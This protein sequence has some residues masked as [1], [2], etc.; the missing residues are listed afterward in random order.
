MKIGIV[1]QPLLG[2]YGGIL[3]NYAL[4][5]VLR[6]L[7][8]D[9]ITLDHQAGYSGFPYIWAALKSIICYVL[10]KNSKLIPQY[11]P[12]R[13]NP[14]ISQFVEHYIKTTHTFWNRYKRSLIKQYNIDVLIVGSDQ[15]WRPCYNLRHELQ[16]RFLEF[17]S[18]SDIT[19][20]AYGASFGTSEWE[21]T[22][23]QA[24]QC[25]RLLKQFNE[26]SVREYS[27]ISLASKLGTSAIQ[28]MDPTLLLGR[29][30]FDILINGIPDTKDTYLGTYI[31][32]KS[33][34][35]SNFTQCIGNK[36]QIGHTINMGLNSQQYGPIEW[37]SAIA[38]SKIFITDS[39][40]GT[41]FCL[42]YHVPFVTLINSSRGADRF[43]SLLEP[44]GLNYRLLSE[45]DI[46]LAG[47]IIETP[48][49][50]EAIDSKL[51]EIRKTSLSFLKKYI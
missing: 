22:N 38:R 42:L 40:H 19:K 5:Q 3:Q 4:Q 9:P 47:H 48:I 43:H 27:G 11:A 28:V 23:Q 1:T 8:H 34:V 16:D 14:K 21:F 18:H 49:D 10:R 25:S 37:I 6:Q 7:G 17:A 36:L 50:W 51:N 46:T 41:V 39:F 12:S 20:I 44:L 35:I 24:Q 13:N 30:G 45:L 26:V 29:M 2:N 31:L 33:E 15:V 32:D